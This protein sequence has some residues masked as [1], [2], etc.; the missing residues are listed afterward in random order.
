MKGMFSSYEQTVSVLLCDAIRPLVK[1]RDIACLCSG[2]PDEARETCSL[3]REVGISHCQ[4]SKRE[5]NLKVI[6]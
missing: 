2:N 6:V 5:R 1:S 4:G 3:F